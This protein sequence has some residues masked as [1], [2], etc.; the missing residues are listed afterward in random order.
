MAI[1]WMKGGVIMISI[2]NDISNFD[3]N[4][5]I[6]G[7]WGCYIACTGGCLITE[8]VAAPMAVATMDLS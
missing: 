3:E 4:V 5:E 1:I 8:M 7:G 2:V 6:G